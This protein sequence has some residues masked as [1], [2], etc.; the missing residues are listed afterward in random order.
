MAAL[1]L[2]RE[3]VGSGARVAAIARRA[4]TSVTRALALLAAVLAVAATA[5]GQDR[6]PAL[7]R[8]ADLVG[9]YAG[10]D[11]GA[12][13]ASLGGWRPRDVEA[14]IGLLLA[15]RDGNASGPSGASTAAFA[16]FPLPAA[17]LL[18]AETAEAALLPATANLH[19]GLAT[20]LAE[21]LSGSPRHRPFARRLCLALA[22]R[23]YRE[24]RWVRALDLARKGLRLFPRD[25]E[26]LLVIASVEESAGYLRLL[27]PTAQPSQFERGSLTARDL[28][29]R[30]EE[31]RHL[32]E[33]ERALVAAIEA[34]PAL[35][36]ARLRLGRVLWRRGQADAARTHLEALLR[37]SPPPPLG[38]L[39]HLFLG[40][41]HEDE[42]RWPD[43]SREYRAAVEADAAAPT[44]RIA[45]AH[46]RHRALEET[47][48]REALLQ[49]MDP[50]SAGRPDAFREYIWG[51]SGQADA[52]FE[53][54]ISEA[55]R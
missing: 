53:A 4:G 7:E 21:A 52:R 40:R 20:R 24:S 38:Y 16:D 15:W 34:D 13:V 26:L 45:L 37:A 9:Q 5:P 17:A 22:L 12:C 50:A 6:D 32:A 49:A 3:S 25:A 33:A 27:P 1:A 51:W 29:D 30:T 8:Y 11:R 2:R 19:L 47:G 10:G 35:F 18:H 48:C 14:A 39:A 31:Q 36:E 46:L 44:P 41:I 54:L 23:A 55:A 28:W 43:A 42:G